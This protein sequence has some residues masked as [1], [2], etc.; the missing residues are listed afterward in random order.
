M[1]QLEI[2]TYF[3]VLGSAEC[4]KR[5]FWRAIC[6]FAGMC[7]SLALEQMDAFYAEF[8]RHVRISVSGEY[9]C[10]T[11]KTVSIKMHPQII[12]MVFY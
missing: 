9:G 8:I 2:L 7:A 3:H 11:S 10:L 5:G 12:K 6:M 1:I 4:E